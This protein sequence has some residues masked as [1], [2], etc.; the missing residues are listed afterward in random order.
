MPFYDYKCLVPE[1]ENLFEVLKNISKADDPEAC[2]VC[3]APECKRLLSHTS[4]VL[5]GGGWAK[6]GYSAA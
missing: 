6:D 1:C 2:P 3:K 5:E 4:F